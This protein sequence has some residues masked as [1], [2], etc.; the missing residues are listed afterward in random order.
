MKKLP[1]YRD[2]FFS[3]LIISYTALAVVLLGLAGGYLYTQANR[4]MVDE[5][6]RDSRSR[7]ETA[8]DYVEG[9]LL[10]KY[11][12]Q[13]QN[14]AVSTVFIRDS[15]DL[16][17]LLD[18]GWEGNLSRIAAFR[19]DLDMFKQILEGASSVTVY[20]RQGDYIV[21]SAN[22][23]AKT[24]HSGDAAFMK[25]LQRSDLNRWIVRTL[26]KGNQAM[27]YAVNLPY[28]T[29][30]NSPKG[31]LYIDVDMEYLQRAVA[32][33]LNSGSERLYIFNSSGQ[34]IMQTAGATEE[35]MVLLQRSIGQGT[36]GT[37]MSGNKTGTLVL[38]HL[39]GGRPGSRLTYAMIRPM[40]SFVLASKQLKAK[41]FTGCSLVLLL[42]LGISYLISKRFYLPMKRLVQ[43]VRHL[44]GLNHVNTNEYQ[45][46]DS[47]LSFMGQKI[48]SLE[49]QAQ[50][51]EMKHLV[52]GASLGVERL[53]ALPRH[54]RYQVAHIQL[55]DGRSEQLKR[56]DEFDGHH[57]PYE[58]VILNPQ[59][60]AIVFFMNEGGAVDEAAALEPLARLQRET[61][62]GLRFGAGIGPPVQT[63]EEIPLSYR[64]AHQAYRYRFIYGP[65]ALVSHSQ[66]A[67][68][69]P[70][71][72]LFSLEIFKNAL[73]AG[74][75]ARA[76]R[77]IDE[78]YA[79]LEQKNLQLEAVELALLQMVSALYESVIDLELQQL[80]PPFDLFDELKKDTLADTIG[81]I[82][83]L[84]ER[85]GIH[86]RE[87]GNH[88]HEEVI[89][90]L[91]AYI[92]EHLDEDLSLN[93]LSEVASL[94]PAYISTLF[95]KVMNESFTEYVTRTRLGKA[96]DMLLTHDNMSVSEIA[97]LVGYRSIQ[98]FHT[99]F[100]TRYGVTPVQYRQRKAAAGDGGKPASEQPL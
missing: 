39:E 70:K 48:L 94:A 97:S 38:S 91:K 80:V 51:N 87:S 6:A 68:L 79:V 85:I 36:T 10:R 46:I 15:S 11:E 28:G 74:D 99:K 14:K 24:E 90:K 34:L 13:L 16:N 57:M 61:G 64:L 95:G 92:D 21:D 29:L 98:Y 58:L 1:F 88:A 49:S 5:I 12:D 100:K 23:Y 89:L 7:L 31:Y 19:Q 59:E 75:V 20:F 9:T 27:T 35:E 33:I 81:S 60:S 8:K 43:H 17:V 82:R 37:E 54:C 44:P 45:M 73:K 25:G 56:I 76:N 71:P 96:A 93:V 22:F 72:P 2:T 52:L 67:K 86:V 32:S 63:I 18:N 69:D 53:D 55:V 26:P 65:E 47:T 50:Q 4:M 3:R 41:I 30:G 84:S 40:D 42:G 83:D 62:A 77:F 78:V 66:I